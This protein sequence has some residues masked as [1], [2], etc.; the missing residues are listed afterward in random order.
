MK[1]L[2]D[3]PHW[4]IEGNPDFL[5]FFRNLHQ[6]VEERAILAVSGSSLESAV[7]DYL[8]KIKIEPR[9]GVRCEPHFFGPDAYHVPATVDNLAGLADMAEH[10]ADPE[11]ADHMVVYRDTTVLLEWYDAGAN[12]IWITKDI[13]E[14]RIASFGRAIGCEVKAVSTGA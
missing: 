10:H 7:S 14:D 11:V 4:A 5:V 13:D 1:Y 8:T 9:A 6:L 3:T 12:P 2:C